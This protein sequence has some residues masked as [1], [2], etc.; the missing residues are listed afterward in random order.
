M[1][2]DPVTIGPA[3]LLALARER[4]DHGRFR[5]LPVVDETGRLVGIVTDGDLRQ[6]HGYLGATRVRAAM[7]ERVLT[8]GPD[9]SIETAAERMLAH[10]LGG[11]PVVDADDRPIG[12]V[13]ETDLVRGLMGAPIE[14]TRARIDLQFVAPTQTLGE[15]FGLIEALGG[16]ILGAEVRERDERTG[17]KVVCLRLGPGRVEPLVDV[18][19]EHGYGVRAVHQGA[20]AAHP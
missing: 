16:T 5:R 12:M 18:L 9:D 8:V 7:C 11:L 6:H 17:A 14:D 20:Y 2:A 19:R 1:T 13:T 15:A 3:D 10:K 4:M